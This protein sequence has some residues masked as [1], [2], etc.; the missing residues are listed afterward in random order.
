MEDKKN[1]SKNRPNLLQLT[2]DTNLNVNLGELAELRYRNNK[3]IELVKTL[4]HENEMSYHVLHDLLDEKIGSISMQIDENLQNKPKNDD[5]LD[6]FDLVEK[7][8]SLTNEITKV[9]QELFEKTNELDEYK[10]LAVDLNLFIKSLQKQIDILKENISND[11]KINDFKL[12]NLDNIDYNIGIIGID[13]KDK[14]IQLNNK[15]SRLV[16]VGNWTFSVKKI[17]RKTNQIESTLIV[18]KFHKYSIFMPKKNVKLWSEKSKYRQH[19]PPTDFIMFE[20]Q[21]LEESPYM[22]TLWTLEDTDINFSLICYLED[23]NQNVSI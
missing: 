20:S 3:L 15:D 2:P 14:Y 10:K 22:D 4:M 17:D 23:E 6:S 21:L 11:S 9:K 13:K 19:R 18:Y 1:M 5:Y 12:S 7:N 16:H 8:I